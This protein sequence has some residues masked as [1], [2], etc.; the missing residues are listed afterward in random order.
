MLDVKDVLMKLFTN[1]F[2]L[3]NSFETKAV[4]KRKVFTKKRGQ[5]HALNNI[6]NYILEQF[7]N[8]VRSMCLKFQPHIT[9]VAEEF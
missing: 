6:Q 8:I 3:V 1:I 9:L 4:E 7:C 2:Q 5:G